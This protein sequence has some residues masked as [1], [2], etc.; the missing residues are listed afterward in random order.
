MSLPEVCSVASAEEVPV[1]SV[2]Q[3]EANQKTQQKPPPAGR[4]K[5]GAQ[6]SRTSTIPAAPEDEEDGESISSAESDDDQQKRAKP[7]LM[8]WRRGLR[9]DIKA[10]ATNLPP[11]QTDA[12]SPGNGIII[13]FA[14]LCAAKYGSL[15]ML[16]API[17][18]KRKES[19]TRAAK[20]AVSESTAVGGSPSDL[21]APPSL[22]SAADL[23]SRR[24]PLNSVINDIMSRLSKQGMLADPREVMRRGGGKAGDFYDK[25][26]DFF[27]DEELI[28]DL[29]F[30]PDMGLEGLSSNDTDFEGPS[31]LY[32]DARE[33]VSDM[34]PDLDLETYSGDEYEGEA[35][36]DDGSWKLQLLINPGG[37]RD[38]EKKLPKLAVPLFVS[39][40][41]RI[42][43]SD[44]ST[45]P[46][47]S[48]RLLF[49]LL[50]TARN[51]LYPI[52]TIGTSSKDGLVEINYDYSDA[53]VNAVTAVNGSISESDVK[54]RWLWPLLRHNQFV[55]DRLEYLLF[56]RIIT[57]PVTFPENDAKFIDGLKESVQQ[58]HTEIK[59]KHEEKDTAASAPPPPPTDDANTMGQ[60]EV[61]P[62]SKPTQ[63]PKRR[64]KAESSLVS[65]PL[66]VVG[67]EIL[68]WAMVFNSRKIELK[69]LGDSFDEWVCSFASF[70]SDKF[71]ESVKTRY[72]MGFRLPR[73]YVEDALKLLRAKWNVTTICERK[74]R[75]A[76]PPFVTHTHKTMADRN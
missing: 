14:Q 27:D 55:Y 10:P 69:E 71:S 58:W 63:Q 57:H 6:P 42:K 9:V 33:F 18:N 15:E 73:R 17:D 20:P 46:S 74:A 2:P 68:D 45:R 24:D 5:T 11:V 72:G 60:A 50:D 54:A 8:R 32:N 12:P 35:D 36:S 21:S 44:E 65:T 19:P 3:E 66:E 28:R 23:V 30:E 34:L 1:L 25:D 37:W 52:Q 51:E 67:G 41:Q 4:E 76:A 22:P 26:D 40:E 62:P 48:R 49:E 13:D 53:V 70:F 64:E 16:Y 43:S 59:R 31:E 7:P 38:S 47:L 56:H 29:G 75:R 61:T 39:L